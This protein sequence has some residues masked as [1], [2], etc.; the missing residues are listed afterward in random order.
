MGDDQVA[1][2]N[3]TRPVGRPRREGVT[4]AILEAALALAEEAGIDG[5]TI[6]GIATRAEISRPTLYRRWPSKDALLEETLEMMVDRY[7]IDPQTGNVRDDL[8]EFASTMIE[9]LQGPLRPIMDFFYTVKR[10]ELAPKARARAKE[11]IR[12]IITRGIERGELRSD[13]NADLLMELIL[14]AIW[15]RI[16]ARNERLDA[17]SYAKQ[18]V[19]AVLPSSLMTS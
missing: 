14:G 19:D 10:A 8:V 7:R 4:E 13:T 3:A 6:D 12:L 9:R 16:I 2:L 5:V 17:P 1:Q 11:Y 18:I 15:F